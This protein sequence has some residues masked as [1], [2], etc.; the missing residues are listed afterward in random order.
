[1]NGV[2]GRAPD[3]FNDARSSRVRVGEYV[4]LQT[5]LLQLS[6]ETVENLQLDVRYLLFDVEATAS[7][8]DALMR[9]LGI[10]GDEEA[11]SA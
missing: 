6:Q 11:E 1:M 4:R 9:E 5:R 2:A 10:G 7:E 8:R 3:D